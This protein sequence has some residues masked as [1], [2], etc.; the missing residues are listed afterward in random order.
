MTPNPSSSLPQHT[1]HRHLPS[2]IRILLEQVQEA[3]KYRLNIL[4]VAGL[5]MLV[6]A[7]GKTE[8]PE[9]TSLRGYVDAL[10]R[11][12]LIEPKLRVWLLAVVDH[13]NTAIHETV[14]VQGEELDAL[15]LP[16]EHLLREIY[17]LRATVPPCP[18]R[19][20]H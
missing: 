6:E 16:V 15:L 3:V 11:R 13:G 17:G 2:P 9:A 1:W 14:A 8:A 12:G 18:G 10:L 5:R 7:V 4:S 19:P 20:A